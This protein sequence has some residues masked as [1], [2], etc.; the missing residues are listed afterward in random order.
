[1]PTQSKHPKEAAELVRFL[2]SPKGQVAA[3]K[4]VNNLPSSPAA[5]DDPA[6]Q[7]FKNPYFNDAPVGQIFGTG[8]KQLQPVYFGPK[9]Q[10]VR[11]A[12]ESTLLAV[13]QG[14]LKPEDAWAKAV[15]DAQQAAK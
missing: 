10:S 9:N 3:F 5:L 14:K 1:V 2:T 15:K 13:Q 4:A 7:S 6:L 12:V 8:A 11:D